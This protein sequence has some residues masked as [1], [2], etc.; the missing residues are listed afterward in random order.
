[1]FAKCTALVKTFPDTTAVFVKYV[2]SDTYSFSFCSVQKYGDM[3]GIFKAF[4]SQTIF[5]LQKNAVDENL[6]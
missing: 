2:P 1:M 6:F 4:E 3:K 5:G